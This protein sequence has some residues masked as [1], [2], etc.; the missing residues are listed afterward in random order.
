MAKTII[1][2]AGFA[3]T[4]ILL[5]WIG[6]MAW[7]TFSRVPPVA[8]YGALIGFSMIAAYFGWRYLMSFLFGGVKP[9]HHGDYEG[10]GDPSE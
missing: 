8:W 7:D 4:M 10:G 9:S 1:G 2:L 5:W 3:A 6:S